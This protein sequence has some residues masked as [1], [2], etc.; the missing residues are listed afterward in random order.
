MTDREGNTDAPRVDTEYGE[1]S[2][3]PMGSGP[4]GE[5]RSDAG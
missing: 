5:T 3:T 2:G 4:T 1:R